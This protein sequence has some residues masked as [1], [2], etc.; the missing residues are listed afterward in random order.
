MMLRVCDVDEH[1][2]G[3]Q[4]LRNFTQNRPDYLTDIPVEVSIELLDSFG[5]G[6]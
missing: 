1:A 4:N 6:I 3:H 2:P 5:L